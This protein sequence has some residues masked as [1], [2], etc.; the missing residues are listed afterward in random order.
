ML[1]V[2]SGLLVIY[3]MVDGGISSADGARVTMTDWHRAELHGLGIKRQQT[4]RQQFTTPM[5]VKYFSVSAAWM[6]PSMPAMAPSTPACEQVGTA[7]TGGGSLNI[8]R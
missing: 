1:Q 5:P 4:V 7:P 3:Q 6:V 2:A 8:Q